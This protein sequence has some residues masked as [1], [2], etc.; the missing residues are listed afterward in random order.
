MKKSYK[1]GPRNGGDP[2]GAIV[3]ITPVH[4]EQLFNSFSVDNMLAYQGAEENIDLHEKEDNQE[5]EEDSE[6]ET[7]PMSEAARL[8]AEAILTRKSA[9]RSPS[10]KR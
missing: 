7:R 5:K 6:D 1:S 10:K 2:Q 8:R 9:G 3:E 4:D